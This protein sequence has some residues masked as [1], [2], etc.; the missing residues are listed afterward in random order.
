[1][2]E[3]IVILNK[4]HSYGLWELGV[5]KED[6]SGLEPSELIKR[7]LEK[8]AVLPVMH[9]LQQEVGNSTF[10]Y[11]DEFVTDS[12]DLL[13]TRMNKKEDLER[14]QDNV[15]SIGRAV[16]SAMVHIPLIEACGTELLN[17]AVKGNVLKGVE[18]KQAE[19]FLKQI[20]DIRKEAD[21]MIDEKGDDYIDTFERLKKEL[22]ARGGSAGDIF[23][24]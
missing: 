11:I 15:T 10:P 6:E 22:L 16:Y 19:H 8:K 4:G 21:K 9:I 20:N 1:M 2:P 13:K 7:S 18:Q 14:L 17:Q 24:I 3:V 5:L 23:D 12:D